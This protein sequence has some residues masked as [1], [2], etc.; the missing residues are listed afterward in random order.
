MDD[1]KIAASIY[2]D[3]DLTENMSSYEILEQLQGFVDEFNAKLPTYKQ[4]QMINLRET[5]FDRT[6]SKKIKR[7][8]V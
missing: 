7:Q 6:S 4:I 8:I 3:P 5:N 1:V 2:P